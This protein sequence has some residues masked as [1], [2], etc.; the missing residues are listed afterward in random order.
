[1]AFEDIMGK[2]Q[3]WATGTEALAVLGA[4]LSL[5]QQGESPPAELA[6]AMN[7][8]IEAAGLDGVDDLVPPQRA[9]LLALTRLFAHQM[10]D[11]LDEPGREPGWTFT[12]PDILDGWGRGSMMLPTMFA[13]IHPSLQDVSSFLDVG[14]GV[15][16]LA[17]AAASVWPK[18]SIV[19][20]DVW[21][22][23][24]ERARANVAAAGLADRIELRDQRLEDLA[25]EQ[26]FDCAWIPTFFLREA[27][28]AASMPAV[29]RAVRPGGSIILGRMRSSPD[30][31]AQSLYTFRTTRAGGDDLDA[32]RL[33]QLLEEVGCTS[34]DVGG[35][36]M[37][38]VELVVGQTPS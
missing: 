32:K 6:S 19:G 21:G 17:C 29:V 8:V 20:L 24:L 23:S 31:V 12:D 25:D 38:P 28:L 30:A 4:K 36:P 27:A 18:S 11:V 14:T 3:G 1:M 37:S 10:I 13:A 35:P 9:M 22:P 34:L 15:G 7:A 16:L 2:V 33:R 5:E 26:A